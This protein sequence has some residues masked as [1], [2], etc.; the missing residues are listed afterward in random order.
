MGI[1]GRIHHVGPIGAGDALS[2][3]YTWAIQGKS[4]GPEALRWGV[5]AGTASA[6]LPGMKFATLEQ[7]REMFRRVEVRRAE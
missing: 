5:A 7:T 3:A 4:D 6:L 1:A 2:A